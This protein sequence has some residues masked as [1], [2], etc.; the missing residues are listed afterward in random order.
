M[1]LVFAF[2]FSQSNRFSAYAVKVAPENEEMV[3]KLIDDYFSNNKF[4]GVT[5][6]LYTIMF[7]AADL[8]F[9]HELIFSG[10]AEAMAKLYSPEFGDTSW[11]LFASK[12]NSFVD[13]NVFSANGWMFYQSSEDV[14]PFQMVMVYS[15]EDNAE[16]RKWRMMVRDMNE[17]YPRDYRSFATGG[18]SVGGPDSDAS[19]WNVTGYK[20]YADY[21]DGW[22]NNQEFREKN[23]KFA[24]EREERSSEIDYSGFEQEK[25]FMRLLV[26]QW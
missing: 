18:I 22:K 25:K 26:K 11:Q 17:K 16:L 8:N 24:K 7:T 5:V 3:V 13:E 12:M 19:A 10:E 9:T 20:T 21:L 6:S 14:Y 1:I 23:P 15:S 2:S 4:E